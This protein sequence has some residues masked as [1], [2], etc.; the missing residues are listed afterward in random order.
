MH[1]ERTHER[2]PAD[3]HSRAYGYT[4]P[5]RSQYPPPAYGSSRRAPPDPHTFDYPASL[6]QYAEWFRYYYPQQAI[7]EDNADKVAAEQATG[8]GT[9]PRNGIKSRWEKYRK[10]FSAQQVGGI[11]MILVRRNNFFVSFHLATKDV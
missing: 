8:D 11:S 2:F 4:S 9:K 6:K 3:A 5:H 10:D 1:V 7:E